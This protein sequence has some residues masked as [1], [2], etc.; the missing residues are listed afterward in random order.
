MQSIFTLTLEELVESSTRTKFRF[1]RNA[2]EPTIYG[3]IF[4]KKIRDFVIFLDYELPSYK[5]EPRLWG[6]SA[7]FTNFVMAIVT[8]GQEQYLPG[9]SGLKIPSFT[10]DSDDLYNKF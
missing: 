3:K 9:R 8:R 10:D 2:A 6:M 5:V 4:T 7:M 1:N